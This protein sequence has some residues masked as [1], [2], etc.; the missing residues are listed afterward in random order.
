MIL[1][2]KFVFEGVEVEGCRVHDMILEVMVS[3]SQESNFVSL[4]G[5]QYGGMPHGHGK[6][7]RLSIHD[8]DQGPEK[9]E[10]MKLQHVRSLTTFQRHGLEKLLDRL[11]EF[12]LLRI[13]DLQDCKALQDKHMRDVCQLYLLRFLSLRSTNVSKMP[14]KVGNLEHLETLDIK[15]TNIQNLPRTL[16]RLCK[17]ECLRC[18]SCL[19]PRGLGNMKALREVDTG[20]LYGEDIPLV[21]QEIGE[22]PQ[23]QVLSIQIWNMFRNSELDEKFFTKLA[24]SLSKT[25]TLRSLSL[26]KSRAEVIVGLVESSLEFLHDVSTPPPILQCLSV[27]GRISQLPD[28]ISSLTHLTKFEVEGTRLAGDQ[29]FNVLCKLPKLQSVQL[30]GNSYN[31]P[32]LVA[33]PEHIFPMLR[34]LKVDRCPTVLTF[35]EGSMTKLEK[36][37]LRFYESE[38]SVVGLENMENLKEVNLCGKKSDL[39]MKRAVGQLKTHPRSSQIKVVAFWW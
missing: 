21:A 19:L 29:L 34:I 14:D 38:M 26:S 4:V 10:A 11:G 2:D 22:L 6:V 8:N 23:L 17:L 9:V 1:L 37:V 28:W 25:S 33:R 30:E 3:K 31:G 12:K 20:D 27:R 35:E 18:D 7:R 36:L 24:S 32:E 5:Q 39:E 13:L 15:N 16:T